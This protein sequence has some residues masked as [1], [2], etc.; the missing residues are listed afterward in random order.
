MKV[1]QHPHCTNGELHANVECEGGPEYKQPI[2]G[3]LFL[4]IFFVMLIVLILYLGC[5]YIQ[6]RTKALQMQPLQSGYELEN[7]DGPPSRWQSF[8]S[9]ESKPQPTE[10]AGA[11]PVWGGATEWQV[12]DKP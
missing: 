11:E 5:T 9:R 10:N 12:E 3:P 6:E 1:L 7:M 2:W 8:F 4:G